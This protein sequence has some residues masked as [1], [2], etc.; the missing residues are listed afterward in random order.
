MTY[1]DNANLAADQQ[2]QKRLAAAVYIEALGKPA[3]D[4]LGDVILKSQPYTA[5]SIFGPTV[6]SAPGFGEKYAASGDAGITDGDLL[7]AIQANWDRLADLQPEP[8][9]PAP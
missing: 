8:A 6:A 9:T 4:K 5:S 3:G 1:Q 7:S 2:Y